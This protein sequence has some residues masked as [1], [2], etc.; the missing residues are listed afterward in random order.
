MIWMAGELNGRK[1]GDSIVLTIKG[2]VIQ[3]RLELDVP[4]E[5]PDGTEVEIRPL[6]Q[7]TNVEGDSMS[8]EEIANA[9]SAMDK[10]MPFHMTRFLL[11]TGRASDHRSIRS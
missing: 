11:Y 6:R 10:V 4:A 2:T 9:L 1:R 8:P 3:R 5:W 7:E